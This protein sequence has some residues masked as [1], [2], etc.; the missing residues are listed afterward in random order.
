METKKSHK[1]EAFLDLIVYRADGSVKE[2]RS[3]RPEPSKPDMLSLVVRDYDGVV[4]SEKEFPVQS[5]VHNYSEQLYHAMIGGGSNASLVD[6]S[7]S[8]L[9]TT[10]H[11]FII[12]SGGNADDYG[13]LVG[14]ENIAVAVGDTSLWGKIIHGTDPDQLDYNQ[15]LYIAATTSGTDTVYKA[16]RTFEN[17]SGGTIT[18]AEVGL[19]ARTRTGDKYFL[20][21]RDVEDENSDPIDVAVDDAETLTATY[22]FTCTEASGFTKQYLQ[23]MESANRNDEV[24]I[25]Y[26][27]GGGSIN[28]FD[29]MGSWQTW[30]QIQNDAGETDWGIVVGTN[31][32][33]L[34][35]TDY[36]L[37]TFIEHGSGSGELAYDEVTYEEVAVDGDDVTFVYK[38]AI[39]NLSGSTINI[40]EA[41]IY[42]EGWAGKQFMI[43]RSLTETLAIANGESVTVKY[44][45]KHTV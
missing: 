10:N 26:V 18:I 45:F 43:V 20:L 32:T 27:G 2:E 19:A 6:T 29:S 39:T 41:G 37:G 8:P 24:D 28:A 3:I 33:A 42:V 44:T 22:I 16:Y 14:T 17:S 13:I 23:L 25:K 1:P 4:V 11:S 12:A 21:L 5:F 34:D 9:T 36:E 31:D 35:S 38:R 15:Q 40:E 7:N 30:I